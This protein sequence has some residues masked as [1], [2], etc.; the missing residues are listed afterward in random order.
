M[1]TTY[2]LAYAAGF[3]SAQVVASQAWFGCLFFVLAT[4][5]KLARGGRLVRLTGTQALKLMGLGALTCTTSIL[6][7]YAMS[8][9]PAPVAL[10]LL[11]QFTWMGLI[12]QTIITRRAPKPLE[13]A[14]AAVI[15][16]GTVFASGVYK[17]GLAGYDPV[18]LVCALGAAVTCSLF[19]TFSG[20]VKASCSN[21]QRGVIVCLGAGIMSLTV[22][23][24]YLVSDVVFQGILPFAAVAGFFGLMCPV[25]LF[26]LGSPHLP[27]GLSTVMAAAE[28]PAGL[29]I[30]MIVL[31]EPLGVIEW[32]GV[33]VILAGVCLAQV[34][35]L[36]GARAQRPT[37]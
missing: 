21:E 24:N 15:V 31:G 3:T 16:F 13:I 33:V 10:T 14:S 25:L 20:K 12:W 2:K 26:G 28:L 34:P 37:A 18:A 5:V 17:T 23:P 19:V 11:F 9:L 30:A 35:A 6:Y 4:A 36:R 29:L 27:A 8:V 22:C 32:L 1:A 7:C